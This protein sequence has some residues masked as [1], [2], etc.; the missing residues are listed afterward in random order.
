MSTY[1]TRLAYLD[2]RRPLPV[3]RGAW[4]TL[5]AMILAWR[6]RRL[7]AQLDDRTLADIGVGRG[8][9]LMEARR[10]LWDIEGV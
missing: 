6:T 10:P 9:A 7:L 4:Q 1:N 5:Q 2:A 8:D 3:R